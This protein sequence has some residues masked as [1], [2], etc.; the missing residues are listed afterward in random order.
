VN[1]DLICIQIHNTNPGRLLNLCGYGLDD[2][3]VGVPLLVRG[4]GSYIRA[5]SGYH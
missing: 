3:T 1:T 4:G 5:V 2:R